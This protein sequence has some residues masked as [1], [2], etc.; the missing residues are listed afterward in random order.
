MKAH[1]GKPIY[2]KYDNAAG[3]LWWHT[4]G[5]ESPLEFVEYKAPHDASGPTPELNVCSFALSPSGTPC[6]HG[7]N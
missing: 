6:G 5:W 1:F 7:K 4:V 3:H 2:D